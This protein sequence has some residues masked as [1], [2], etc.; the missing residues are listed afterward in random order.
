MNWF[1][2]PHT[3]PW[4]LI[5]IFDNPL[6]RLF[7]DPKKILDGFVRPGDQVLDVGCGMGYF[8][9]SLAELVGETGC[10]F[11]VDLQEK[12]LAALRKRAEKAGV[13]GRIRLHRNT[14]EEIGLAE[15][16]D[17]ALA[18]WMVHEVRQPRAFLQEVYDLLKTGGVFLVVEPVIHVTNR[19]F[20]RTV[21][22][23]ESLGFS[24]ER[25]PRVFASRAVL[26]RK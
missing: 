2:I 18:F 3:C 8:T 19:A 20:V 22:Q 21:G 15:A 11:A 23:A 5:F 4:W 13:M 16:M 12:M 6:R 10:V 14:P 17:F 1:S 9:L 26:L 24:V 7:Q 25:R